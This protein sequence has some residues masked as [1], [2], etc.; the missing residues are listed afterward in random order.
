M[1]DAEKILSWILKGG[2]LLTPFL[3]LIVTRSLYFPFITGKN[4]AFRI[5][6]E[7]LAAVWVYTALKFARFRPHLT[8]LVFAVVAFIAVMGLATVFSLS[9]YRSFWSSFERMEGYIGLLHLFLYFLLLASVFKSERDWWLFFHTSLSASVI[10]SLYGL[11]QLLGKLAIHQGRT[12][13]DATFGNATYFAAYLLFH[14][15]FLMWFFLRTKNRYARGAYAAAFLLES[16]MLYYTATRGAILG[17]LGGLVILAVT[18][19]IFERGTLRRFA[20]AG[21]G[22]VVLVVGLFFLVRNTGFVQKSPV[23]ERFASISLRETT[24]QSRFTIWQMALAGWRERPILG[25]GQENFVYVFSKYYEPSLWRQEP[26]FDRA[27]N[28]FLDWMISGGIL[29][30]GAYLAMFGTAIAASIRA[31]RRRILDAV[32]FGILISLLAAHFFQNLFVFDN[33]TSYLLFFALLAYVHAAA[34][35]AR[36]APA[37]VNPPLPRPALPRAIP[38]AV[39]AATGAAFLFVF[40]FWSVKPILAAKATI[41]ALATQFVP[42]A[43]R[44]DALIANFRKGIEL[45]TFGTTELREQISQA[46]PNVLGDPALANQDKVKFVEYAV[47]ELEAQHRAAPE[48]MRAKAFLATVYLSAGRPADA[49]AVITEALAV[50]DRRPHFYFVA[51]E[52]YLNANQ[53]DEAIAALR[54]AYD[55]APEF[56]EANRNLA[57]VLILAGREAE[58][59][60]LLLERYATTTVA[61]ERIANAYD[62]RGQ[63]TK[64]LA[65]WEA[66]VRTSQASAKNRANLGVMYARV[67]RPADAIREL[68]E[69]IRLEPGFKLQGDEI[70]RQIR[71][72]KFPSR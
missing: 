31:H 14:L 62:R 13:I 15:F 66:L 33:L 4:F 2:L 23:L 57:T 54:R 70:I 12:R 61:E 42:P 44:V 20:L 5:L 71:E 25:W 39:A 16:V 27:H 6:V 17:L 40:F 34:E 28:V 48:D 49:I 24:T 72:G 38:W 21:L 68:E 58:A 7:L 43:G 52:A 1:S 65:V 53:P 55:L 37:R 60:A 32:S 47:S 3:V 64:A 18:L 45:N 22:A 67:G 56:P 46:V 9:P 59:E 36:V 30:L 35:R 50:S 10:V 8:S 11:F 69:A 51:A 29:G 26:W 41:D 19:A 63:L